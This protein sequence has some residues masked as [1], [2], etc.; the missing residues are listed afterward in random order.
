MNAKRVIFH[1]SIAWIVL[2]LSHSTFALT[3]DTPSTLLGDV[4]S[5]MPDVHPGESPMPETCPTIV[6]FRKTITL[7]EA[8]DLALCKNPK[9]RDTWTQIKIQAGAYGE[10]RATWW[11]T[12]NLT[13][14]RLRTRDTYPDNPS[15]DSNIIGNTVQGN[16]TWRLFD[17]GLRSAENA[18]AKYQLEAAI[19]SHNVALQEVMLNT[20]ATY[21]DVLNARAV[22]L[23]N[24]EIAEIAKQ[25]VDSAKRRSVRGISARNEVATAETMWLKAESDLQRS[26]SEHKK[27][28]ALLRYHIGYVDSGAL[29]LQDPNDSPQQPNLA[30]LQTWLDITQTQHPGIKAARANLDAAMKKLESA[31]VQGLPSLDFVTNFYKNGFPNQGLLN[32]SRTTSNIGLTLNVP[33]FDG[34]GWNYRLLGAEARSEQARVKV[35][36]EEFK[37][38]ADVVRAHADVVSA[39]ENL[40]WTEKLIHV[41]KISVDSN[42]LRYN[43]GVG[44]LSDLLSSLRGLVEARNERIR[45]LSEWRSSRLRLRAQAGVLTSTEQQ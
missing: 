37:V 42:S 29:T 44:E 24:T 15:Q 16:F 4:L 13:F 35:D 39:Y 14:N 12:V 41:A 36:E 31:R 7:A 23:A 10:S 34:F 3:L 27:S 28:L 45:S 38:L 2:L 8:V 1:L 33:L 20:I 22:E 32:Q 17:W 30:D 11:P 5:V 6:N 43:K 18:S 9:V 21:F 26:R 25:A 19:F 40:Q